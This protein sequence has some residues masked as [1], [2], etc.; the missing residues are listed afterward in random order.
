[1]TASI[2]RKPWI[3]WI[4][5]LIITKLLRG[6]AFGSMFGTRQSHAALRKRTL[7]CA[8]M[9]EWD[10]DLRN[11]ESVLPAAHT[12]WGRL[13]EAHATQKLG[14][15]YSPVLEAFSV[16]F[17]GVDFLGVADGYEAWEDFAKDHMTHMHNS[18][19]ATLQAPHF[20]IAEIGLTT[21]TLVK[22]MK[23]NA[24]SLRLMETFVSTMRSKNFSAGKCLVYDGADAEDFTKTNLARQFLDEGGILINIPYLSA[25]TVLAKLNETTKLREELEALRADL[26]HYLELSGE[27]LQALRADLKL[28]G[29]TATQTKAVW[30]RQLQKDD[31]GGFE[32]AGNAF[33]IDPV[34]QNI[35][36]LKNAIKKDKP[37]KVQCDADEIDIFS[38]QQDGKWIKENE[39]ALVNRGTSKPLRAILNRVWPEQRHNVC[40]KRC[41]S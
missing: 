20:L 4:L 11:L 41:R 8:E 30:V 7:C 12:A 29:T 17:L 3:L 35:A 31:S 38:Q 2:S 5:L 34:P 1:M 18:T 26:E 23:D 19:C 32:F 40:L 33:P 16:D 13:F 9:T 22:K 6:G 21:Q 28:S 36:Y 24:T 14:T 27:E 25:D 15:K 39:E 10:F 37:N